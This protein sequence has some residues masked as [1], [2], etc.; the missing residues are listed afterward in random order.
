MNLYSGDISDSGL[1][2]AEEREHLSLLLLHC[3]KLVGEVLD[4][5]GFRLRLLSV[6]LAG[7]EGEVLR[8]VILVH[9][10]DHEGL[11]FDDNLTHL[12]VLLLVHGAGHHFVVGDNN[13][14]EESHHDN[15]DDDGS[16]PVERPNVFF[17]EPLGF[18]VFD[19]TQELITEEAKPVVPL[20]HRSIS[21]FLRGG[22]KEG[23]S[24]GKHDHNQ[25]NQELSRT[26]E[27]SH[28]QLDEHSGGLESTE[29]LKHE[30]VGDEN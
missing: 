6:L 30:E 3:I 1:L 2:F 5:F 25:D 27:T 20:A 24:E 8:T 9:I 10:P 26:V 22:Y 18:G 13:S 14:N 28:E 15:E 17:L 19:G 4:L 21:Q 29:E 7:S 23:L 16:K 12:R 11:L